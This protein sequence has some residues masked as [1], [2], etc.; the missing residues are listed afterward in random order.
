M[1]L[2][3]GLIVIL[4]ELKKSRCFAVKLIHIVKSTSRPDLEKA[5]KSSTSEQKMRHFQIAVDL[6]ID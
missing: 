6:V 5:T 4:T 3:K 2:Y 1:I